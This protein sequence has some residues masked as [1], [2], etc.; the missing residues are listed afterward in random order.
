LEFRIE[1]GKERHRIRWLAFFGQSEEG[2]E[3]RMF[4]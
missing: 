4:S 1:L 3:E 2:E